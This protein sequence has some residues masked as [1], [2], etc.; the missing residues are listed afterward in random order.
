MTERLFEG[1]KSKTFEG[2]KKV[3]E[4]LDWSNKTILIAEDE[5]VNFVYLETALSK[6]KVTVLRAH[7]GEE[8][9]NIA[10]VN[11]N[12]DL[13]LMDIKMPKMNGIEAT[14]AIKSFRNDVVIVAQTAFAMEEDKQNCYAVGVDGFLAKPVRY[15][16][17]FETIGEFLK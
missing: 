2:N 13:I 8:A 16:L 6:T 12:I 5:D 15:K 14:R 10:R 11:A 9:V 1:I 17:L 3:T 4:E 7:N